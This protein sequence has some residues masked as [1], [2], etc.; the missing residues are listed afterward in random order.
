MN[1]G[2]VDIWGMGT[3]EEGIGGVGADRTGQE[4]ENR[5]REDYRDTKETKS[6]CRGETTSLQ[7]NGTLLRGNLAK[8]YPM[9]KFKGVLQMRFQTLREGWRNYTVS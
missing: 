3:G 5:D 8:N 7:H 6:G 2:L 1:L 4:G 9:M